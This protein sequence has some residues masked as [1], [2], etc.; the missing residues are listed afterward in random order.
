MSRGHEVEVAVPCGNMLGES[1]VWRVNGHTL[2]WTD[3]RGPAVHGF[4]PSTGKHQVWPMA[5]FCTGVGLAS[6]GL[7]VAL[8]RAI[9]HLDVDTGVLRHL[10]D[11]EPEVEQQRLNEL[12]VDP[13]GRIWVGSMRDFGS[14]VSG[15][16]YC[17]SRKFELRRV[18]EDVRVP[19]SLGWSPDGRVMYFADSGKGNIEAFDF[20][21]VA[22]MPS[23]RR[24][25][26]ADGAL[27]G[28]P[29]GSA[30]DSEGYI[31]NARYG[32]GCVAR[33]SPSGDLDTL[34]HLPVSRPTSCA[35][36][37]PDLRTLF[38]TTASQ[39]LD[40]TQR[41]QQPLAGHLLWTRVSVAGRP[42]PEFSGDLD[43]A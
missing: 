30:L 42:E 40:D 20:D 28:K 6:Q 23:H 14:A 17:I 24:T 16:L 21:P 4:T 10:L 18:L 32:A 12:K 9:C 19:N 31:W 39:R 34:I 15:S 38:I 27:P 36:G 33:V 3:I 25:L 26:L 2:Y 5:E 35:L 29:D 8:Q 43:N 11:V 37:G 41:S 1:P 13:A 22:G 7:L